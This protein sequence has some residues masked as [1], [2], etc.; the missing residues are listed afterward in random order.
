MHLNILLNT[1]YLDLD[2]HSTPICKYLCTI[3]VYQ[4]LSS[5]GK[6]STISV[7]EATFSTFVYGASHEQTAF[8]LPLKE[9]GVHLLEIR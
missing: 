8:N 1:E 5:K 3:L 9:R 7:M 4:G 6:G 2:I